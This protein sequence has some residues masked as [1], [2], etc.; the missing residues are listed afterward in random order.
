MIAEALASSPSSAASED[1]EL[2]EQRYSTEICY[3]GKCD[4]GLGIFANR[5]IARGETILKLSGPVIDFAETKRRGPQ[6][7]VAI[8][9]GEDR[10]IDARPPGA[11][12]NH[13]C[14]PNAGI[15]QDRNLVALRAIRKG[16]EIRFDYSTTMEERPFTMQCRCG[17]PGCR[18]VIK[19]FPALPEHVRER[20]I[21]QGIVMSFIVHR[22]RSKRFAMRGL[23]FARSLTA[24]AAHSLFR[25][26]PDSSVTAE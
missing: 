16:R 15:R 21:A 4:V 10:Y 22:S 18:H 25:L 6:K 23:H 26:R 11:F 5:D 17:A 9:V 19:D 24:A 8:Q 1:E 7:C 3:V 12:V 20:Y 2:P 14:E 13:S